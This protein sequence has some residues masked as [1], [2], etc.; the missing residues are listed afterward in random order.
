MLVVNDHIR[1]PEDELQF[2][3]AR[4]SGPGGQNVNKLNTKATLHWD[5]RETSHLPVDVRRRFLATFR[6]RINKQG[7][8]VLTSQRYRQQEKNA[9]DCR[10]KLREMILQVAVAPTPRRKTRP[11]RRGNERRLENK[12]ATSQRKQMRQ[13]P[14]ID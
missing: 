12:R 14:K 2:S 7:Q 1:V 3:Y 6:N 9:R 11:P 10:H 5:V 4:S 8:V 13:R